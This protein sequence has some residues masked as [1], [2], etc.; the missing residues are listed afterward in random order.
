MVMSKD[1]GGGL[2]TD[3]L[4]EHLGNSDDRGVEASERDLGHSLNA[5]FGVEQNHPDTF[6]FEEAHLSAK[7]RISI[8]GTRQNGSFFW[9]ESEQPFA[10][11]E[12]C[13]EVDGFHWADSTGLGQL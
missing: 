9:G 1:D 11:L 8:L 2:L 12:C 5:I 13:L 4:P 3:R 6:L 7:E 10:Q